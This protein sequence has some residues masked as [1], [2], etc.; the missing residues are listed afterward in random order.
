MLIGTP[1]YMSPEQADPGRL[2]VDTTTDVYSLGVMLYELLVGVLPF[3]GETLRKAAYA[4]MHRII[5]DDE[6]ARPSLR[7]THLGRDGRRHGEAARHGRAV[8]AQAAAGRPRL[9]RAEGAREGPHAAL[10]VGVGVRRRHRAPPR[11]TRR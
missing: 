9:D 1:E 2:D 3:D 7:V 8:A 11:A 10:R 5:Q 6:P 4:E